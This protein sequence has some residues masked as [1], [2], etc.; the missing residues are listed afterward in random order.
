M[1][2]K[3][4]ARSSTIIY[5]L[6]VVIFLISDLN[7]C[8]S[9]PCEH[10][11]TC[12]DQIGKYQCMCPPGYTSTN[13]EIGRYSIKYNQTYIRQWLLCFTHNRLSSVSHKIA[14]KHFKMLQNGYFLKINLQMN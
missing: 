7:E 2:L 13:C 4:S 6:N 11:A 10:S 8:D 14:F 9:F 1:F 3:N 5:G 12:V